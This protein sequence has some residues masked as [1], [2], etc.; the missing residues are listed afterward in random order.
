MY[1]TATEALESV[2][3]HKQR[4]RLWY[5]KEGKVWTEEHD[6]I[7]Y[8]SKSTGTKPIFILVYNARSMGGSSILIDRIV[9]I[10]ATSGRVLYQSPNFKLPEYKLVVPSDLL[11]YAAN[12]LVDGEL[13]VRFRSVKAAESWIGF[14]KGEHFSK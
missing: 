13:Y 8:V 11:D 10:A 3:P 5:G 4:I 14:M 2:Y 12:V 1:Q 6:V 9:K 7:G